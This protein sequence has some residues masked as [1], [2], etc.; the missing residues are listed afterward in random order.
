LMRLLR[1]VR[2]PWDPSRNPLFQ[3]MISLEPPMPR[4]DAAWDLTQSAVSSGSTKMD[5]YLNLDTRPDGL[6]A[7]IMYNPDLFDVPTVRRMFAD[8]RSI[9][10]SGIAN[11]ELPVSKLGLSAL[12]DPTPLKAKQ[13]GRLMA[14]LTRGK[15]RT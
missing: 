2:P 9:L 1:E 13:Q 3:I 8:W 4:I 7:P 5:M 11:P 12:P 15:P 14:W 10:E 6:L